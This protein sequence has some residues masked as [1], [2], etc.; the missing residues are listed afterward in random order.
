[1][2]GKTGLTPGMNSDSNDDIELSEEAQI[3]IE[4]LIQKIQSAKSEIGRA[5]LG[6]DELIENVLI[7]LLSAGHILLEGVPGTAK[8]VLAESVATVLGLSENRVQGTPDLMPSDIIG[9]ELLEENKQT[10]ERSF[11]FEPGPIF[12]NVFLFDEG[13]RA[14]PRTQAGALQAMQEKKVTVAGE[15]HFLPRVFFMIMT[16]N[17]IE[18]E[19]TNPLPEAQMDRFVLIHVLDYPD[20]DAEREVGLKTTTSQYSIDDI[21]DLNKELD[22]PANMIVKPKDLNPQLNEEEIIRAQHLVR[23][24]PLGDEVM[25]KIL[26]VVRSARP[27]CPDIESSSLTNVFNFVNENVSFGPGTRAI[28]A[29]SLAV[30]ARALINGRVRANLDDVVAMA[31]PVLRHRLGMNIAA[32]AEGHDEVTVIDQLVSP[33]K[34]EAA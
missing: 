30:R 34:L 6:Q 10:G 14:S 15:N 11:R 19:G 26:D 33:L 18:Q 7:S 13:N 8:T 27:N 17:P 32:R 5:V 2:A 16:Q 21:A 1:M 9:T 12:S 3:F 29:L 22:P 28:Q 4:D 24:L 23:A 25:D 31:D 20:R